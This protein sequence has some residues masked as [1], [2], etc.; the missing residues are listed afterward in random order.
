MTG[1]IVLI[2]EDEGLIILHLTEIL[3]NA[4]HGTGPR[5]RMHLKFYGNRL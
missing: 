3:E 4:G 2:V 5:K 1:E